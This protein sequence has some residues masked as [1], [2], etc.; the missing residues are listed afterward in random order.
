MPGEMCVQQRVKQ[1]ARRSRKASVVFVV[2]VVDVDDDER[3]EWAKCLHK[4]AMDRSRRAVESA[5]GRIKIP[6]VVVRVVHIATQL[7]GTQRLSFMDYG[8]REHFT[9]KRETQAKRTT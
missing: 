5:R 4:C 7:A 1:R 9:R 3:N 6:V 2:V 8:A